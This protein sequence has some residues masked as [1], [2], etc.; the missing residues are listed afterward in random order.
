MIKRLNPA[1]SWT[2]GRRRGAGIAAVMIMLAAIS[3]AVMGAISA[4]GDEAQV[5]AMRA[6]TARA[7]YAAE[8]GARV[9]LKCSTGGLTL[10][11]VGTSLTLGT[12]A[13]DY[14]SLPA[15]G[16]PGDATVQGHDGTAARRLRVT[17]SGS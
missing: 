1:Q 2:K 12:A 3:L 17:L 13:C 14:V 8:S 5:G 7:F 9:A 6:E 16:Q 15:A 11:T 4:S 10:P